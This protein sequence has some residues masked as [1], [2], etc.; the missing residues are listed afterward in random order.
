MP[1]VIDIYNYID[2]FA[3]FDTAMEFDNVGILVGDENAE[4]KRVVIALD[5]TP[6]VVTEAYKM[7]ANLIVSHHPIIF[8]PIKRLVTGSVPYLLAE[9]GMS[10]ICAHTNLD[11]SCDGTNTAM[12]D[13]LALGNKKPLGSCGGLIGT[14]N[15]FMSARELAENIK[16]AFNCDGLR[17][18]DCGNSIGLVAVAAGAAGEGIFAAKEHN[19]HAFVTGE[20]KHHEILFARENR[21]AV[22]DVGHRKCEE[23]VVPVLH[24]R[25][26]AEFP[27][28]E[29]VCSKEYTDGIMYL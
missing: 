24:K 28:V 20:I 9:N 3:P 17:Y 8:N 5:I 27:M 6:E 16:S 23:L 21:I 14:L 15:R 4:V 19:V 7:S 13:A 26:K 1:R 25:L 18:S 29:F 10:A 22:Y 2:T 11:F 12:F